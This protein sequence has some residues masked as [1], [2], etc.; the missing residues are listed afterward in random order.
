MGSM[1]ML[2]GGQGLISD[3]GDAWGNWSLEFISLISSL[4]IWQ[5]Y[6]QLVNVNNEYMIIS[7]C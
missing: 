7:I 6:A 5:N 4:N 3:N 2:G 1:V